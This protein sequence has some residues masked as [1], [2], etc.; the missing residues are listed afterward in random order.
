MSSKPGAGHDSHDFNEGNAYA[1]RAGLGWN[2]WVLLISFP[3]NFGGNP[4]AV[5]F[6]GS[7]KDA[8]AEAKKRIDNWMQRQRRKARLTTHQPSRRFSQ[9]EGY[10]CLSLIATGGVRGRGEAGGSCAN[11]PLATESFFCHPTGANCHPGGTA[12]DPR[13]ICSCEATEAGG[14]NIADGWR[15][16]GVYTGRILKDVKPADLPVKQSTKFE[17]V[18]NDQTA[19][20]LGIAVPNKL[21]AAADDNLAPLRFCPRQGI[22]GRR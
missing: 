21:L 19:R 4:S 9:I 22:S 20:T 16:V 2:E 6:S 1:I 14:P 17:L 15:R 7:R 3:D 10:R 12:L 8:L 5:N 18:I 11:E 13:G